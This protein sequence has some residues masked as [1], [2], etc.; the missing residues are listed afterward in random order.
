MLTT[1]RTSD[2]AWILEIEH[3]DRESVLLAKRN[4]R[5]VHHGEFAADDLLERDPGD[6]LGV[7]VLHGV[8]RI[9]ALHLRGLD[10]HVG[11]HL[12]RAQHRG[13]IGGEIRIARAPRK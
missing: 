7:G 9:Y 13:G 5:R 11:S 1:D 4:C 3:D 12:D 10:D 6:E 2:R 8:G